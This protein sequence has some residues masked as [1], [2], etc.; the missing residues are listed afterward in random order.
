MHKAI[1]PGSFDPF[2]TAHMDILQRAATMFDLVYVAILKNDSKAPSFCTQERVDMISAATA[3]IVN[4]EILTYD[5]LLADLY[6]ELGACAS[7]RG[8]RNAADYAYECDM[9][10]ANKHLRGDLETVMLVSRPE[11]SFISSSM[12]KAIAAANGDIAGLV[13]DINKDFI[14]RRLKG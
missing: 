10:L 6:A 11:L 13:P 12:V 8:L 7:V 3:H 5:G 2:T 9:A 4:S 1:F 14:S